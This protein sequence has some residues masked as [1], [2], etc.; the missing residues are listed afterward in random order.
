MA[1]RNDVGQAASTGRQAQKPSQ[2]ILSAHWQ[3]G[4]GQIGVTVDHIDNRPVSTGSHHR[5]EMLPGH[6]ILNSSVKFLSLRKQPRSQTVTTQRTAQLDQFPPTPAGTRLGIPLDRHPRTG[7]RH[8]HE[9]QAS[10][11]VSDRITGERLT[12]VNREVSSPSVS[13]R[14][15]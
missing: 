10:S 15:T 4:Q 5:R 9:H 12:E 14:S 13:E 2:Q 11:S 6:R 3:H 8:A 1:R 7:H